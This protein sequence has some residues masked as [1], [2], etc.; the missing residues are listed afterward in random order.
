MRNFP[1]QVGAERE[2]LTV[3]EKEMRC[4]QPSKLVR[5]RRRGLPAS[6]ASAPSARQSQRTEPPSV[7]QRQQDTSNKQQQTFNKQLVDAHERRHRERMYFRGKLSCVDYI[8]GRPAVSSSGINVIAAES[9]ASATSGRP[10]VFGT[11][12]VMYRSNPR[13]AEAKA[14]LNTSGHTTADILAR[15]SVDYI[16]GN[17]AV[18]ASGMVVAASKK[19]LG[20]TSAAT[21]GESDAGESRWVFGSDGIVYKQ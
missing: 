4:I 8:S 2:H 13:A 5:T 6:Y 17:P 21:E 10:W 19:L 3:R 18:S 20:A 7:N 11:D 14:E 12:G 1:R 16:S 9:Q 15:G